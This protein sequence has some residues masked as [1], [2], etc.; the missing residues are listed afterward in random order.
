MSWFENVKGMHGGRLDIC[1]SPIQNLLGPLVLHCAVQKLWLWYIWKLKV[2]SFYLTK[3]KWVE[4]RNWIWGAGE[5]EMAMQ[6]TKVYWNHKDFTMA[7]K[8]N[9]STMIITIITIMMITIITI[10][11][12]TIMT[13]TTL[14]ILFTV[15]TLCLALV[16]PGAFAQVTKKNNSK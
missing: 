6:C 8:F 16:L 12:I 4:I 11:M 3:F 2:R 5:R 15:A 1:Q 7:S 9:K 13:I 10:T 14:T